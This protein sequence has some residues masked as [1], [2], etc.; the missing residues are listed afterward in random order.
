MEEVIIVIPIY[1]ENINKYELIALNRCIK[2]LSKYKI[3]FCVPSDLNLNKYPYSIKSEKFNSKYFDSIRS[4]NKLMLSLEFYQRFSKYKYILIY[5]LDAYVFEDSLSIWLSSEYDYIGAPWITKF[6]NGRIEFKSKIN[7][8]YMRFIGNGGLSLRK[9]SSFIKIL[10][11]K[12]KIVCDNMKYLNLP[13]F[14]NVYRKIFNNYSIIN[15][16]DLINN[17]PRN[18]DLF[19][20]IDAPIIFKKFKTPTPEVALKFSFEC[21]PAGMYKLNNHVLPF[22]CHGWRKYDYNFW[23]EH[24]II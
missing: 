2:V 11:T 12:S 3:V 9:V 14:N 20:G 16:K 21:D 19:W 23:K 8:G 10:K 4:Y 5:Q 1:K 6:K 15:I 24:I 7:E 18:E 13:T 22:G 17:Y